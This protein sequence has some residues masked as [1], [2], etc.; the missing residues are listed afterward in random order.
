VPSLGYFRDKE[1]IQ[2]EPAASS[3]EDRVFTFARAGL[4][5]YFFKF[6]FSTFTKAVPGSL[7]RE[8][9]PNRTNLKIMRSIKSNGT[10]Q[11]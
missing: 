1:G 9:V 8:A 10:F 5:A 3:T 2:R 4:L 6:N 11:K 7:N